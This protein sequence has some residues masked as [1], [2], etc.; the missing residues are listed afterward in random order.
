MSAAREGSRDMKKIFTYFP[1]RDS[2]SCARRHEV[3]RAQEMLSCA[4]DYFW[5]TVCKTVRPMLS[6]RCLSCTSV[7][8]SCP[9]CDVGVFWP[10][11][12]TDQDETWHAGRPRT[13]PH[14]VR[15]APSSPTESGTAEWADP[16]LFGPL[17]S[18]A[19]AHLSNCWALVQSS[20]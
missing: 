5:A 14:C 3:S 9:V 13:W 18:G 12:W 1:R 11:G 7:C 19:I 6:D 10:N 20:F 15:R 2:T 8:L 17:C 4:R 16:T